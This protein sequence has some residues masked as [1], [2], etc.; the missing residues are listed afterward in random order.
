MR[1]LLA[2]II[3]LMREPPLP[4]TQPTTGGGSCTTVV[5]QRWYLLGDLC[6]CMYECAHLYSLPSIKTYTQSPP[7]PNPT[8]PTPKHIHT[9]FSRNARGITEGKP[10]PGPTTA[11]CVGWGCCWGW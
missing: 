3:S 8:T 1:Q 6:V 10:P 5:C 7:Q 2:V 11:W 4:M 9:G